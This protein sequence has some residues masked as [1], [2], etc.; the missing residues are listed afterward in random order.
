[1]EYKN[2][3]NCLVKFRKNVK[4]NVKILRTSLRLQIKKKKLLE[5]RKAFVNFSS[6]K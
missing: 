5:H 3:F 4:K 1:M 2:F 6:Y